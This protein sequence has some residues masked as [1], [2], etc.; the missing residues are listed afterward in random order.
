LRAHGLQSGTEIL[1]G[2]R[3][4]LHKEPAGIRQRDA[5]RGSVEQSDAES[6]FK[7]AYCVA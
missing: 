1:K 3:D 4:L 5:A 2:R 6:R 7:S